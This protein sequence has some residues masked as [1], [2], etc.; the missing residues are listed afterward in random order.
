MNS[1]TVS[2]PLGTSCTVS[3]H[4]STCTAATLCTARA[5]YPPNITLSFPTLKN[6]TFQQKKKHSIVHTA[7][8]RSTILHAHLSLLGDPRRSYL[9][10]GDGG[11]I[12]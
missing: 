10:G 3:G 6:P 1:Q 7:A 9:S 12:G 8:K 5:A 2:D 11:P 4:Q